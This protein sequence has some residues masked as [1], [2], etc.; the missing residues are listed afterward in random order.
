[1]SLIDRLR[2]RPARAGHPGGE[3]DENCWGADLPT[4]AAA[5]TRARYTWVAAAQPGTVDGIALCAV[6]ATRAAV[7]AD[8]VA[9]QSGPYSEGPT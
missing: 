4:V 7:P 5:S 9:A 1:M 6:I 3:C 8:T 2:P